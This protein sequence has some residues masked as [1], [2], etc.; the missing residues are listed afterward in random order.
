MTVSMPDQTP[1]PQT[2]ES[3]PSGLLWQI[4]LAFQTQL[5]SRGGYI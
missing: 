4:G 5:G 2:L 3:T 1:E